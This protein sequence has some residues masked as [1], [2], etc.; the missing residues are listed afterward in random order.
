MYEFIRGEVSALTPAHVVLETPGG[1]GYYLHISLQTYSSIAE[2]KQIRLYTHFIVRED[3]QLL[4]GF[5]DPIERALFRLLIGVSGVGGNTARMVLSTFSAQELQVIIATG[6]ADILKSVKGLGIKTAQKIIVELKDKVGA[7][8]SSDAVE[9]ALS[10]GGTT[11]IFDE[12]LAA[13]TMLGFTKAASEKVL[14]Q[15]HREEP[16]AAVEDLVRI[17]LKRL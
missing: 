11:P 2:Q 4:F 17:A 12:A 3:T 16:G 13:L 8:G 9:A 5:Y 14:R 7:I 15:I 6:K 1:V 10:A